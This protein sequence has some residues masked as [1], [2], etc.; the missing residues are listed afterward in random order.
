MA[1]KIAFR[2]M[3]TYD[4]SQIEPTP[5]GEKIEM[6]C[7][8][9]LHENGER[10]LIEDVPHN[11]YEFIQASKDECDIKKIIEKSITDPNILN[12]V[13]GSYMDV[14]LCPKT[15]AEAQSVVLKLKNEYET[16]P[17]DVK[18]Q[19]DNNYEKYVAEYGSE[20]WLEK[21][22]IAEKQRTQAEV[23]RQKAEF[24]EKNKKAIENL[25]NMT[26]G[27]GNE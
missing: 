20:Q 6:R 7:R 12:Q 16:L 27:I 1:E 18:R 24:A 23:A 2:T 8:E 13:A 10:E 3:E 17:T 5:S 15:L 21:T 11:I 4:H 14:T 19:F 25:A 22:G 26:G 9:V